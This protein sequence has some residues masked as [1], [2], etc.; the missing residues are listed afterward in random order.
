MDQSSRHMM[1]RIM[2]LFKQVLWLP[3]NVQLSCLCASLFSLESEPF[4]QILQKDLRNP[5]LQNAQLEVERCRSVHMEVAACCSLVLFLRMFF[6]SHTIHC[7]FRSHYSN[8]SSGGSVIQDS[9]FGIN[10][11]KYHFWG[12]SSTLCCSFIKLSIVIVQQNPGDDLS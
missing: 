8:A 6:V 10:S 1:K 7:S 2:V 12:S 3:M 4:P 11:T 5:V 9:L